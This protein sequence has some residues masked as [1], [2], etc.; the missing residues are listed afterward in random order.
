MFYYKLITTNT[1]YLTIYMNGLM[2]TKFIDTIR[3]LDEIVY[4]SASSENIIKST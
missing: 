2:T 4:S 3:E 1:N